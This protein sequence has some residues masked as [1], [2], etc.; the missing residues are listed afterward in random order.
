[1]NRDK[2]LAAHAAFYQALRRGDLASLDALWARGEDVCCIHPGG[3]ALFGHEAVMLSWARILTEGAVDIF[4]ENPIVHGLDPH[5][6]IV[7]TER[8]GTHVLT[9]TNML[10][11]INGQ[12]LMTHHHAGPTPVDTTDLDPGGA[13]PH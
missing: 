1:M 11:V 7:C 9:A 13:L 6:L 12:Y 4:E 10:R 5:A 3:F 2:A 8:V